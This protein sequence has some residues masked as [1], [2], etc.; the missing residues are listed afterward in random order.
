MVEN[1]NGIGKESDF[2]KAEHQLLAMKTSYEA[3][4]HVRNSGEYIDER[5][6][7]RRMLEE[8][9]VALD[10]RNLNFVDGVPQY[11]NTTAEVESSRYLTEEMASREVET[12]N[13]IN[14]ITRGDPSISDESNVL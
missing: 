10:D 11:F 13:H 7:E 5:D 9:R 1:A 4:S 3:E 2:T 8:Y 14:A 6:L 12:G